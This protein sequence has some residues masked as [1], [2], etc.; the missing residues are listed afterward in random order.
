MYQTHRQCTYD[1]FSAWLDRWNKSGKMGEKTNILL[2]GNYEL[3]LIIILELWWK[4]MGHVDSKGIYEAGWV[5]RTQDDCSSFTM[6]FA[7]PD[8]GQFSLYV[9]IPFLLRDYFVGIAIP[10]GL[11]TCGLPLPLMLFPEIA[12]L[13]CSSGSSPNIPLSQ[14]SFL[15]SLPKNILLPCGLFLQITHSFLACTDLTSCECHEIGT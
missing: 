11:C 15:T 3:C 12:V 10:Q 14:K 5:W 1:R 7:Y 13:L 9:T 8:W 6:S 2:P 4:M